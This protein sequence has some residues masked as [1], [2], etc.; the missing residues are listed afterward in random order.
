MPTETVKR[1]RFKR[2]VCPGC[3]SQRYNYPGT[4][5]R[6]GIDSVVRSEYCWSMDTISYDRKK[7]K[8]QCPAYRRG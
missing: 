2:E 5:E 7:K 3:R 1:E 8:W 4:C 6:P